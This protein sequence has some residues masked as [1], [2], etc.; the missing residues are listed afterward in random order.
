MSG[1]SSHLN[2]AVGYEYPFPIPPQPADSEG[3]SVGIHGRIQMFLTDVFI[4]FFFSGRRWGHSIHQIKSGCHKKTA[5][6]C[7]SGTWVPGLCREAVAS[8]AGIK[9]G[10]AFRPPMPV[11]SPTYEGALKSFFPMGGVELRLLIPASHRC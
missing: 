7:I 6:A 11:I 2:S 4:F 8:H 3:L 5:R 10:F 9:T 1:A